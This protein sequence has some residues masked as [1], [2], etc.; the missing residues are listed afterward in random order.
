[1]KFEKSVT[2]LCC[3]DI[4][5]SMA[6]YIEKLGF[7][8]KWQW[9]TPPTFGGVAKDDVE[10]FFCKKAQGNPGTWLCVVV[11][12]VDDYYETIKDTGAKIVAPPQSKEWNMR[13]MLVEDPDGHF[14]RFGHRI[15]DEP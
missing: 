8:E 5:R 15:E 9:D 4:E 6:Y 14:I 3:E 2:I 1:M 11:D 10:I 7:D 12:N 13:E